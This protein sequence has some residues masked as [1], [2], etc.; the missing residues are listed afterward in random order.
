MLNID[1][2]SNA[3]EYK[4]QMLSPNNKDKQY[5]QKSVIVTTYIRHNPSLKEEGWVKDSLKKRTQS[6]KKFNFEINVV[7]SL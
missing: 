7:L 6:W 5:R 3:T 4:K 2:S 1:T